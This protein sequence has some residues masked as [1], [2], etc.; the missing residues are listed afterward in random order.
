[1]T[2]LTCMFNCKSK[3]S[4]TNLFQVPIMSPYRI[5]HTKE[6]I[7]FVQP[8][9]IN[10]LQMIITKHVFYYCRCRLSGGILSKEWETVSFSA[11]RNQVSQTEGTKPYK[12]FII[13]YI[14]QIELCPLSNHMSFFYSH[15]SLEAPEDV[16]EY[17]LSSSKASTV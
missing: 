10:T 6:V 9:E 13:I 17:H 12:I 4:N 5:F 15:C 3:G 7:H 14:N 16:R 1:M 8:F 11:N 2:S